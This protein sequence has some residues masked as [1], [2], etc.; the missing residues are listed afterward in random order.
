MSC[1]VCVEEGQET[2]QL[3]GFLGHQV[4]GKTGPLGPVRVPG[5]VLPVPQRAEEKD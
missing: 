2:M 4:S 5:Q 1:F 3:S